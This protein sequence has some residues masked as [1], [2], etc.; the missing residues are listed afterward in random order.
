MNK[1][2][3]KNLKTENSNEKAVIKALLNNARKSSIEIA[4]ETGVTR[5]T[6]SKI[7]NKLEKDGRIWGYTTVMQPELLDNHFY[8]VL[9]KLKEEINKG[10]LI[11]KMSN[12]NTIN[13][14]TEE[15]FRYSAYLH[16]RFDL[17]SSFYAP[18]IIEAEKKINKMYNPFRENFS[19][20]YIHQVLITFR[21]M[22]IVNPNLTIDIDEHFNI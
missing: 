10:E 15:K 2:N 22:G 17:M 20:L 1:N 16:G 12:S 19:E 18:N 6:V 5:Q 4:K 13:K 3:Q 8:L 21:R 9:I 7:I 11:K 14:F